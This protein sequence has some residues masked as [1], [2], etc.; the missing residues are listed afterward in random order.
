MAGKYEKD[1]ARVNEI[2]AK[3][4]EEITQAERLELLQIYRVSWHEKGKIE[5][6]W[7][8]DSSCNGCSFCQKM[9]QAAEKDPEII[10]GRCYDAAQEAYRIQVKNRHT[11]NMRIMSSVSFTVAELATLPGGPIVR[12]N[13]SGDMENAVQAGNMIKYAIAHPFS[14]VGLWAKNHAAVEAAID[15]YGKPSNVVYIASVCRIN[16]KP[17]LPKYADYTFTV[18]DAD[19]I[20]GAI[21]SGA[22]ECNGK[23]C[24]ECGFSCYL[25][26]WPEGSN[27]AER[28]R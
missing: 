24:K 14:S 8:L 15:E 5:G 13:S 22:C 1:L 2:L 25:R 21:A 23:K 16:G 10:C 27:I 19:H 11:L 3:R 17:V 18:Y 26:S 28:L 20:D 6:A 4:P 12:I 7:S 9:R